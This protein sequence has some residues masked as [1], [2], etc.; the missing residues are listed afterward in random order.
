MNLQCLSN[1]LDSKVIE[2]QCSYNEPVIFCKKYR[3]QFYSISIN[4]ILIIHQQIVSLL[5]RPV[6]SIN[7]YF[8][9][10]PPYIIWQS[11]YVYLSDFLFYIF[12]MSKFCVKS[13]FNLRSYNQS[14]S[15]VFFI[16]QKARCH[17]WIFN[18]FTSNSKIDFSLCLPNMPRKK[19]AFQ[20]KIN[21]TDVD[22]LDVG[23]SFKLANS[24][25]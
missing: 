5:D 4:E 21:P 23:N 14:I 13:R 24:L 25:K 17:K 7:N 9:K 22:R 10:Q 8:D 2:F 20:R 12:H 16:S 6:P 11:T 15:E 1:A 18:R 19:F 3:E